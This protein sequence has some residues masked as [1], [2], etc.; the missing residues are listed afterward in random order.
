[1]VKSLHYSFSDCNHTTLRVLSYII[2]ISVLFL[3]ITYTTMTTTLD[4]TRLFQLQTIL[5][6]STSFKKEVYEW[7]MKTH[8]L[9]ILYKNTYKEGT[10]NWQKTE[11]KR[12]SILEYPDHDIT[13][14][15]YSGDSVSILGKSYYVGTYRYETKNWYD[16]EEEPTIKKYEYKFLIDNYFYGDNIITTMPEI[17]KIEGVVTEILN[18]QFNEQRNFVREWLEERAPN[19]ALSI[20]GNAID[21]SIRV[22]GNNAGAAILNH[23]TIILKDKHGRDVHY[24]I[25]ELKQIS[26]L[27]IKGIQE[28]KVYDRDDKLVTRIPNEL[29]F[30]KFYK[31]V[32]LTGNPFNPYAM[33]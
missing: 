20:I 27:Y 32:V 30:Y 1:M 10:D 9:N 24:D 6:S 26:E 7:C 21:T 17:F 31:E 16:G 22:F 18:E 25:D 8:T 15:Q 19:I 5:T 28:L 4:L 33:I 3:T 12:N 13:V 2:P 29:D 23:N 11:D 14:G